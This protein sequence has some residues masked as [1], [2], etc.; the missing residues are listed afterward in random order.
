MLSDS[1]DVGTVKA[2]LATRSAANRNKAQR[3]RGVPRVLEAKD[4]PNRQ[5]QP[6]KM[7]LP[8]GPAP[9]ARVAQRLNGKNA[10]ASQP[11]VKRYP[12]RPTRA[13]PSP[14][15]HSKLSIVS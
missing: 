11:G 13:R 9:M 4:T 5:A 3:T 1:T 2:R 10:N 12:A 7:S 8:P 14:V 15:L 6:Y